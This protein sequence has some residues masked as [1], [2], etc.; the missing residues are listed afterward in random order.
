MACNDQRL[1][2]YSEGQRKLWKGF[3]QR[4]ARSDLSFRWHC[5]EGVRT[6]DWF[7]SVYYSNL[8]ENQLK[9]VILCEPQRQKLQ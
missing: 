9:A 7:E 8:G 1:E 2:I 5:G 6:V 4:V 3:K